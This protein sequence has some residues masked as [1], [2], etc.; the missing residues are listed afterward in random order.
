MTRQ[1]IVTYDSPILRKH[2]EPVAEINDKVKELV[3][4]MLATLK[5]AKGLGLSAPQVGVNS[6]VFVLDL[7]SVSLDFETMAFINPEIL[8]TEGE[9]T[10]EEGCLSFPGLFLEIPRPDRVVIE[11]TDRQGERKEIVAEGL[12][13]RA[14]MHENDHLNGKLFI[15][16]L[17]PGDR[18]MISG[19]LKKIKAAS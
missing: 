8:E 11:F 16:Y 13:A 6:R 18:E 4:S 2:C 19:K 15:D 9:Q 14:I 1:R 10:G 3:A 17:T 7:S 5:R 12:T